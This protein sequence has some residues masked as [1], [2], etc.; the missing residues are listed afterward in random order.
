M[1]L[2][3][4]KKREKLMC[5]CVIPNMMLPNAFE[6]ANFH[7][8]I[9]DGNIESEM[10]GNDNSTTGFELVEVTIAS[11]VDPTFAV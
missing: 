1:L 11:V 3:N 6:A 9:F 2:L 8:E 4:Q 10:L 7:K 5:Q